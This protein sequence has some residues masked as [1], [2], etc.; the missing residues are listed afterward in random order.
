MANY[1]A[2]ARPYAKAVFQIA[3]SSKQ[4]AEWSEVLNACKALMSHE[5]I[6]TLLTDPSMRA[7][8]WRSLLDGVLKDA[9]GKASSVLGDVLVR[10]MDVILEAHRQVALPDIADRYHQLLAEAQGV[11]DVSMTS[12]FPLT[13]DEKA[14][15]Q[16]RLKK[17]FN[18]TVNVTFSVDP[19]LIG[20]AILRSGD[21]VK[22]GSVRGKLNTLAQR[23]VGS[24]VREGV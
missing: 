4:E 23:L 11:K 8:V 3:Q 7:S 24:N 12:A 10:F 17:Q 18:A 6:E 1:A 13:N 9:C 21:W 15:W 16:E 19:D 22:D 14:T 2:V 5:Q 20:G